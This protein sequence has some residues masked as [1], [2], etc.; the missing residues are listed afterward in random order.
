M[1]WPSPTNTREH[2]RERAGLM[3]N[4]PAMVLV[5]QEGL[6]PR[7]TPVVKKPTDD[8]RKYGSTSNVG[9]GQ[10]QNGVPYLRY[11][12]KFTIAKAECFK[13]LHIEIL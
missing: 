13:H 4:N 9:I 2:S 5:E 1:E 6:S 3:V 8:I 12:S 10:A 11:R 7:K